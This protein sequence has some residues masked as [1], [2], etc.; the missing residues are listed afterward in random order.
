MGATAPASADTQSYQASND[1]TDKPPNQPGLSPQKITQRVS[2]MDV[3]ILK[4]PQNRPPPTLYGWRVL[5]A[6][7]RTLRDSRCPICCP[8]FGACSDVPSQSPE[9]RTKE[10]RPTAGER[11]LGWA[12]RHLN[13]MPL[14]NGVTYIPNFRICPGAPPP[15]PPPTE[16]EEDGSSPP[17]RESRANSVKRALRSRLLFPLSM[18]EQINSLTDDFAL[19]LKAY[20]SLENLLALELA[21]TSIQCDECNDQL[22]IN[23]VRVIERVGTSWDDDCAERLDRTASRLHESPSRIQR[24]LARSKHGALILIR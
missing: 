17:P 9:E 10:R 5:R 15:P 12:R 4:L 14:P 2:F 1:S 6:L 7:P 19:H 21:R 23:K 13:D 20:T 11:P 8:W 22:L 3:P 16:G 18:I 24:A